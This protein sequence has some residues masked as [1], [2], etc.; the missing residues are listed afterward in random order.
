MSVKHV[1]FALFLAG[2]IAHSASSQTIQND[3]MDDSG[4]QFS[5]RGGY[6]I[7][8][9]FRNNTPYIDY[10]GGLL[11]G[12]SADYYWKWFG[13]GADV[14]YI[15]NQPRSTYPTDNLVYFSSTI[16]SFVLTEAPITRIFYGIGPN[17]KFQPSDRFA[18]EAKLRGGAA[19]IEGGR[20]LLQGEPVFSPPIDLNFHTGYDQH[21]VLSAKGQLSFTYFLN[22]YI[23]LHA[24]AYYIHHFNAK[25]IQDPVLGISAGYQPFVSVVDG[26]SNLIAQP[27]LTTRTEPCNCAISSVGAFAGVTFRFPPA[28]SKQPEKCSTCDNYSL[29]VTARDK[30]TKELLANTD[31]ALKNMAG[32]VVR[33]GTTNNF[34]VVSFLNIPPNDYAVSGILFEAPLDGA[35]IVKSEF[36]PNETLQKEILYSDVN[37][38]LK[39]KVVM[40]NSTIPIQDVSV[41]L[42]NTGLSEQKNTVT[43]AKGEFVF[44]VKQETEYQIYGKKEQF[45]SQTENISTGAYSRNTTLFVKLEI[46]MEQADCDKAIVLKNIHYDL[47]KYFLREEAKTELRRLSQ[48][49]VDNPGIRV[50]LRSHTDSRGTNAYNETLSQNRANSAVDYLVSQGI[51]RD[52]LVGKGYG[53]T[54]L[55]N[56]CADGFMCPEEKHQLNRRT[57]MKVICPGRN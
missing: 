3:P 57:E 15:K 1:V 21:P 24:G 42:K 18:I 40:C 49:M 29:T 25:E 51:G 35:G 6:D 56:E 38:I 46:C 13:I 36:K 7:F 20:T 44:R 10:K 9:N 31:I 48:F 30:F 17:F 53:E 5:F 32:E 2:V 37:F 50:E 47:D 22:N 41:V 45:F 26:G 12:L 28:K 11:L 14:D 33:T 52:R 43:D 27:G 34:G 23:G 4:F 54:K 55:L 39:G 16:N 19:Y 8:P